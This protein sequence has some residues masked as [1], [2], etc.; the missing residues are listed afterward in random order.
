MLLR[1]HRPL[2]REAGRPLAVL[3]G[4]AEDVLE[5]ARFLVERLLDQERVVRDLEWLVTRDAVGRGPAALRRAGRWRRGWANAGSASSSISGVTRAACTSTFDAARAPIVIARSLPPRSRTLSAAASRSSTSTTC[6]GLQVAA[7]DEAQELRILIGDALDDDRAVQRAGQQRVERAPLQDAFRIRN[8]IA[9]RI[10][11][12]PARASRRS[13]R[14]ADRTRRARAV[15]LPRVPRSS[16]S[17]SPARET[18][19]SAG[20]GAGRSAASVSPPAVSRTPAYGSY[21]TS[22]D[23]ASVLTIVVAVPGHDA[24]R[25]AELAHRHA[26]RPARRCCCAWRIAFR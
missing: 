1:R 7:L 20:G 3:P 16:S 12:G 4:D 8:R 6:P 21:L 11:R 2:L 9:V 15:R 18:A 22:P 25:G 19:R 17:P 13:A 10:D 23:S 26:A 14:S 24:E 5:D